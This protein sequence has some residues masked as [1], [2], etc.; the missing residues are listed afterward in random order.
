VDLQ[1]VCFHYRLEYLD[2]LDFLNQEHH[3]RLNLQGL[4]DLVDKRHL[5]LRRHQLMLLL[6]NLNLNL[7][8]QALHYYL[9]FY[10]HRLLQPLLGNLVLLLVKLLVLLK[11]M[12]DKEQQYTL[13]KI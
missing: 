10:L 4:K 8:Y 2:Y 5:G 11:V 13:H 6:K 12:L 3:H 1:E 9:V 7:Y